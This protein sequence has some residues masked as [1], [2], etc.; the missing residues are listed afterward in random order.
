VGVEITGEIATE[1]PDKKVTL[2]HGGQHLVASHL[3]AGFH[4]KVRAT[5]DTLGVSVLLGK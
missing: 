1:F 2:I 3:T 4:A 5:L